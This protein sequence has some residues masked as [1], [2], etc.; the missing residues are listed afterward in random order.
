VV[1]VM[2]TPCAMPSCTAADVDYINTG[3]ST[4]QAKRRRNQSH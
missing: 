3:T 2:Q 1:L 4:Q